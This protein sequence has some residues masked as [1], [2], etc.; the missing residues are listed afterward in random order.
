MASIQ[1]IVL[2]E[3]KEIFSMGRF[4]NKIA[5]IRLVMKNG[6][7]AKE[8]NGIKGFIELVTAVFKD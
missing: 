2:I 3:R 4:F 8:G 7:G 6:K 1:T 5:L